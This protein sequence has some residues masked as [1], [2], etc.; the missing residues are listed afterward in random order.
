MAGLNKIDWS[1]EPGPRR[2]TFEAQQRA[3]KPYS[4]DE[5]E[6]LLG[7]AAML[8]HALTLSGEQISRL[9][10]TLQ[11]YN[12]ELFRADEQASFEALK[13]WPSRD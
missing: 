12:I 11:A 8:P 5:W 9:Y 7:P 2:L 13:G 1:T 3:T 6:R 4:K 10:A